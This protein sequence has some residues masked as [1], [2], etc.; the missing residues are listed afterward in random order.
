[1]KI[2]NFD[3]ITKDISKDA[4]MMINSKRIEK[5]RAP[6]LLLNESKFIN[7]VDIWILEYI[8]YKLIINKKVFSQDYQIQVFSTSQSRLYLSNPI[9][10]KNVL[11]YTIKCIYEIL[12]KY[13]HN[14]SSI[15]TLY[16]LIKSYYIIFDSII[17][18]NFDNIID[19][20]E[21]DQW[22]IFINEN[23]KVFYNLFSDLFNIKES[24]KIDK[25]IQFLD[26]LI[27]EFPNQ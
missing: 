15:F 23:L 19:I 12:K 14:Q 5:Y 9:F 26:F 4:I 16:I 10:S 18:K 6:E 8:L 27:N 7:K 25:V 1:M 24:I 2:I 11:I 3:L 22:K 13:S 20:A 21:Y 17:L